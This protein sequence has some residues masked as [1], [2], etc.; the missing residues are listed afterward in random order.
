MKGDDVKTA[1]KNLKAFG[2]TVG[3]SGVYDEQTARATSAAK[4]RLGYRDANVDRTYDSGLQAFLTYRKPT[5]LMRQRAKKRM[6]KRPL[7]D[8]ALEVAR[9]FIGV[10]ENPPNSNKVMFS[11]WYGIIGPWCAMF[12]TYCYVQAN[13]KHFKKGVRYA[14]CPFLL[15]DARQQDNGLNLI[16]KDKVQAGDIVLF[17]WKQDGVANHVGLVVD[18]PV[19]D[20]WFKTIEGNTSITNDSNGGAV[21]YRDRNVRDV[22]GF[23]RVWE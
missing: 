18:P 17:S 2:L 23:V 19:K 14:Y 16:T 7:R 4:Y 11:N 5:M 13:A 12:V 10:K 3:K 8:T 21:M 15:A 6:D 9:Q 1:Q 22:I 20:G